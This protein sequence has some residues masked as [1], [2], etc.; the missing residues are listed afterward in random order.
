MLLPT[1]I[2]PQYC[3]AMPIFCNTLRDLD[4]IFFDDQPQSDPAH[5][6]PATCRGRNEASEGM[7]HARAD[8][9]MTGRAALFA[10]PVKLT[11]PGSSGSSELMEFTHVADFSIRQGR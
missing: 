8:T 10:R 4:T 11:Q 5:T 9:N 3:T 6:D 1:A 7:T 2:S